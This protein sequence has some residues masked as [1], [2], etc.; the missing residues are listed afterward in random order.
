MEKERERERDIVSL[1]SPIQRTFVLCFVKIGLSN[2]SNKTYYDISRFYTVYLSL[3]IILN[4][5]TT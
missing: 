4:Y 5:L 1:K 2:P 3:M